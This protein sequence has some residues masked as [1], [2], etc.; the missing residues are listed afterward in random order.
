MKI[1]QKKSHTV[2]SM[3]ALLLPTAMLLFFCLFDMRQLSHDPTVWL[4][5]AFVFW[6][7]RGLC[8]LCALF[9]VYGIVYFIKQLF[10]NQCLI[11]I[12]DTALIDHSSA[13][14]VG[15]IPFD[16]M[17][18]VYIKNTFLVIETKAPEMFLSRLGP[19]ARLLARSNK[20]LGY[21]VI[22]I[23]PQRFKKQSFEF[24]SSLSEKVFIAGF[25]DIVGDEE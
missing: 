15:E 5:S 20:K 23:S 6:L 1:K 7:F 4:D 19:V 2:L 25:R 17:K 18:R 8:A 24:L 22:C 13:I 12:N 16:Q 3:V 14:S 9:L 11:E 10:S 21:D